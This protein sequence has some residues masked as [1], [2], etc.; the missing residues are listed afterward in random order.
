M[1]HLLIGLNIIII[2]I[3]IIIIVIIIVSS[4]FLFHKNNFNSTKKIYCYIYIF[5]LATE[6]LIN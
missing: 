1:F 3:I 4:F 2:I 6:Y 5:H